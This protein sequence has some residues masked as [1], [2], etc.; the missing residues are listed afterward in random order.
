VMKASEYFPSAPKLRGAVRLDD[1]QATFVLEGA[2]R[3]ERA[4]EFVR[5]LSRIDSV[6]W[7]PEGQARRLISGATDRE[8]TGA[9]FAQVNP[10]VA[11]ELHD[12]VVERAVNARPATVVDAYC[13]TGDTAV[14]LAARGARVTAIELDAD[15]A[16]R[17]AERLPTG[18]RAIAARV[19]D[20][21]GAALP[22]D[23]V[24]LNPPR[25]GVAERVTSMLQTTQPAP[26]LVLYVSCN[27]PTLARDLTRMAR[28]DVVSIAAFDMFPQTAHVETV[29]ELRP[30]DA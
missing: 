25:A 23:L 3:W 8:T 13:G 1:G 10:G 29:C 17:C 18:S 5:R 22:A 14:S 16:R 27:P 20:V 19:E 12:Y 9:S 2:R 11:A 28:Y 15:A 26:R 24:I 6:W 4:S 21:L 7:D 30:K